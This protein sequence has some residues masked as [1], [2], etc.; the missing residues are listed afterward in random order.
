VGYLKK[1]K[2]RFKELDI[3]EH[4]FDYDIDHLFFAE[5]EK[6]EIEEGTLKADVNLLKEE[7]MITLRINIKGDVQIMCD[8]CLEYFAFPIDFE[9]KIYIKPQS[10]VEEEKLDT[11][12]VEEDETEINLAQYFYE[13]IH[14]MLPLKRVHPDDENGN[15]TCNEE[16]LELIEKYK[17]GEDEDS[18]DPRWEKLKNLFVERN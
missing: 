11:I 12:G 15:S 14:L 16:M 3:G 6:T 13:S 18:I 8:R 7:R 10:E 4:Q 2:L 1:Y 9:G 5:F 17:K